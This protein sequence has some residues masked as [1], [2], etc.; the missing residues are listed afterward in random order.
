MFDT[1]FSPKVGV[2]RIN[3]LY[4]SFNRQVFIDNADVI[5]DFVRS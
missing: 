5:T 2:E 3:A 1:F 4:H